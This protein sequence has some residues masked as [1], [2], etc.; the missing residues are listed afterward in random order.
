VNAL[1]AHACVSCHSPP[2]IIFKPLA[3]INP[4]YSK[5]TLRSTKQSAL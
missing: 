2:V 5:R 3:D 1:L 4:P